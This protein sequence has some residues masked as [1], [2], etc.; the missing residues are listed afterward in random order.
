[1]PVGR[2]GPVPLA[3][4]LCRLT[5][6][7]DRWSFPRGRFAGVRVVWVMKTSA[8]CW[9]RFLCLGF[10]LPALSGCQS[11]VEPLQAIDRR[12]DLPRF[13]GDWYVIAHI[14]IFAEKEAFNGVERYELRADGAIATTYT[15]NKGGFDGP[16]KAYR[17]TGFVRN[18]ETNAEW[19]MQFLWPFQATYLI[20]YLDEAYE[21]T[22]IGVPDRDYVWV[23]ARTPEI[24]E[25]R[26]QELVS[27]LAATGHDL[28]QLRRVPQTRESAK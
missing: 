16:L 24:P 21:T 6:T 5:E 8:F 22:I 26:Y 4:G 1:M 18:P 25:A 15:F 2:G 12:V 19:G 28:T 23:M 3:C 17:P 11:P 27:F 13:M 10:L 7:L 9:R 14:P 20:V